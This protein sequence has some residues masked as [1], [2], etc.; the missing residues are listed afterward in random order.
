MNT[1]DS[2]TLP[3]I[4]GLGGSMHVNNNH[5]LVKCAKCNE[6]VWKA[7]HTI[8]PL[9]QTRMIECHCHGEVD[10]IT[11]KQEDY[12]RP[13]WYLTAYAFAYAFKEEKKSE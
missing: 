7:V 8:Y 2:S 1:T 4:I 6:F 5:V 11:I 13:D 3:R 12:L 9:S 10:T